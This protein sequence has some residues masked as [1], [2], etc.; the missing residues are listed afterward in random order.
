LQDIATGCTEDYFVQHSGSIRVDFPGEGT[1]DK[2]AF[3]PIFVMKEGIM[4][5]Y[6]DQTDGIF[7]RK[8]VKVD[9][10]LRFLHIIDGQLGSASKDKKSTLQLLSIPLPHIKRIYAMHEAVHICEENGVPLESNKLDSTY[11]LYVDT[12]PEK[13]ATGPDVEDELPPLDK[14]HVIMASKEQHLRHCITSCKNF[15]EG[16]TDITSTKHLGRPRVDQVAMQDLEELL[17]KDIQ[18]FKMDISFRGDA[19][20]RTVTVFTNSIMHPDLGGLV[21]KLSNEL[22]ASDFFRVRFVLRDAI[23]LRKT[24]TSLTNDMFKRGVLKFVQ[25]WESHPES[26][27]LPLPENFNLPE[28]TTEI[29]QALRRLE[30]KA[31]EKDG[32]SFRYE[33][34][35][36]RAAMVSLKAM[37]QIEKEFLNLTTSSGEIELADPENQS[38]DGSAAHEAMKMTKAMSMDVEARW[39]CSNCKYINDPKSVKCEVCGADKPQEGKT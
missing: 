11:V 35:A 3:D 23:A 29:E 26:L 2:P 6:Y 32:S 38:P 14:L 16:V 18:D 9:E 15:T 12:S 21:D 7:G 25:E 33:E 22:I 31:A 39:R 1:L 37:C 4:V 19:S 24:L 30:Q 34:A 27:S 8:V 10:Q 28:A 17:D 20:L 5:L 13:H 36:V